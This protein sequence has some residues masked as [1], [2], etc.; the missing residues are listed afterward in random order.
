M[1]EARRVPLAL[2]RGSFSASPW[3][4]MAVSRRLLEAVAAGEAPESLRVYRP[5]RAL[6]FGPGDHFASGYEAACTA[7]RAA[8]FAPVERLAG[9]RA[10]V[11]HEGTI[12]L[13]WTVPCGGMAGISER[14][15]EVS[16]L[17]TAALRRL[18]VDARVGEVPGEYCAGR[19]SVNAGGRTKLA[20]LGQRV[21]AGAAHVGGVI[22]VDGAELVRE[23]LHGVYAA[24]GFEWSPA[25]VGSV[26]DEL[27]DVTWDEVTSALLEVASERYEMREEP[28]DPGIVKRA[29][30]WGNRISNRD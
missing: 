13:A 17:I 7:A 14:Y 8:G 3:L 15:A 23:P 5:S 21:T 27:G 26:S 11:F 4:D 16:S 18:G 6:A 28:I 22:V 29:A 19:Y 24:L 2:L 10:A 9:G 25:T 30:A 12:A 1:V 20:G